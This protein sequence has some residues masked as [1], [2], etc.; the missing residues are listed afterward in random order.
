MVT[1]KG[2]SFVVG[3]TF[4]FYTELEKKIRTYEVNKFVQIV[5]KDSRTLEAAIKIVS[6]RVEGANKDVCA[7][8][9]SI[10][11][12]HLVVKTAK[13]KGIV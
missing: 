3:E 4:A 6:K 7:I 10:S 11:R 9:A 13:T 2:M 8:I 12:V 5:H 1:C